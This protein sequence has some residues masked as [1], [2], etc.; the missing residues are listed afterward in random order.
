M[1]TEFSQYMEAA[2]VL[3]QH[4]IP[5]ERLTAEKAKLYEQLAQINQEIRATRKKLALCKEIQ[6]RLPQIER[7]INN[8]E[9]Y[10]RIK[11]NQHRRR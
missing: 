5:R 11:R 6:D 9:S 10:E 8:I 1:E 7:S 4:G 3:E 2:A